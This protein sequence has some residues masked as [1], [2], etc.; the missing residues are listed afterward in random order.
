MKAGKPLKKSYD[1]ESDALMLY[2]AKDYEYDYS[3]ELTDEVIVDFDTNGYPKAFEFLNASKLFNVDKINL[4]HIK[5]IEIK[6]KITTKLIELST[7]IVV[8]IHNKDTR[9][10]LE[11]SLVN[12]GNIPE[13][14]LAFV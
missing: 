11:N 7:L 13:L 14:D 5:N 8:G 9:T 3:L 6:I 4:K 1:Y 2:Y 12:E 10:V